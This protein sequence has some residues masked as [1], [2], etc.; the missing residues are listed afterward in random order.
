MQVCPPNHH[1][2]SEHDHPGRWRVDRRRMG[3]MPRFRIEVGARQ[4][5]WVPPEEYELIGDP[6][7]PLLGVQV[8][9]RIPPQHVLARTML[10]DLSQPK[11]R[12]IRIAQVVQPLP[13]PVAICSLDHHGHAPG[14]VIV[15][16][17]WGCLLYTSDAA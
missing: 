16:R 10:E 5:V 14:I 9:R 13:A 6:A 15:D 4:Q 8:V 2:S 7:Y 1:R 17:G 12:P 11:L 3:D